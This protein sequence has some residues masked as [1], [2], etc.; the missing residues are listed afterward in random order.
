MFQNPDVKNELLCNNDF[1]IELP[2]SEQEAKNR[3]LYLFHNGPHDNYTN[4]IL[5]LLGNNL[6]GNIDYY[7]NFASKILNCINYHLAHSDNG[8]P[9]NINDIVVEEMSESELEDYNDDSVHTS[10]RDLF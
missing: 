6:N 9:T 4:Q 5:E 8:K 1:L 2:C 10:D 3:K 7:R